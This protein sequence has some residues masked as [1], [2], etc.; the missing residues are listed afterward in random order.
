MYRLNHRKL[1]YLFISSALVTAC[2]SFT[3]VTVKYDDKVDFSQF[4]TYAWLPDTDQSG[5]NDFDNDLIRKKIRN[6]I[7]H[8]LKERE[9]ATDTLEPDLLVRVKWMAEARKIAAPDM[10]DRPFYYDRIYYDDPYAPRLSLKL[11]NPSQL[12]YS[13]RF[14]V[15]PRQQTYFHNGVEVILIDSR[16]KEV[17]WNGFTS[18]DIYDPKIIDKELHPSIHGMMKKFPLKN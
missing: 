14:P 3:N 2:S 7:G 4:K 11:S 6:Y 5:N 18:D 13:N 9:Y 1:M 16:T 10:T 8:C 15:T 12:D 17:V